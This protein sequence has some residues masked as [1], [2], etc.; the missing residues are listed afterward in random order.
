MCVYLCVF[1]CVC[2][3]VCVCVTDTQTS[4]RHKTSFLVKLGK[5]V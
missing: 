2:V 4:G 3:C 5:F 1:V